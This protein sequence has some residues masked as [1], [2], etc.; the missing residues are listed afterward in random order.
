MGSH[1]QNFIVGREEIEMTNTWI[2][3]Q[4]KKKKNKKGITYT[5]FREQM[6][7]FSLS[8]H[9][10]GKRNVTGKIKT[11][12]LSVRMRRRDA[13]VQTTNLFLVIELLLVAVSAWAW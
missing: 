3:D 11:K 13:S 6:I 7:F 10:N 8:Q 4:Y 9:V 1:G 5:S 12:V 2:Y